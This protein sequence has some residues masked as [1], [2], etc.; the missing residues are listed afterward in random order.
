MKCADIFFLGVDV[1]QLGLDQRKVNML[2]REYAETRKL[3]IKPIILSHHMILGLKEGQ[4]KMSKSD[5]DSAI[6][7]EDS[8]EEVERKVKQAYCPPKIIE[9]NPCID[10][11]KHII[12]GSF[13]TMIIERSVENGGNLQYS[14]YKDF[15]NAYLEGLIHPKDLKVALTAYLNKLLQ[16]VRDH[17]TKNQHAKELYE[18]VCQ[19]RKL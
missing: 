5:P 15:E 14:N 4:Q 6:F 1:C 13:N 18:L 19:Y 17:F 12:F 16:P 3:K 11:I 9:N 8:S 2:A 7:M 10:Y